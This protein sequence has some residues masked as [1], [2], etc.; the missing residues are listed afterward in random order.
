MRALFNVFIVLLLL[1]LA[2]LLVMTVSEIPRYGDPAAPTNN[3]VTERYL[4]KGYE[5]VGGL[6]L[7]ANIVVGYRAFDTFIEIVV[8]FTAV[9]A[10]LVTLKSGKP[11]EDHSPHT[12]SHQRPG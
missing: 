4:N 9:I 8:L 5:E 3:Y 12:Q 6:N 11:V 2:Q 10:I 1:L 7:V